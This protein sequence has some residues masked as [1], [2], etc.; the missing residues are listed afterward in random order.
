MF[1]SAT[2]FAR[3]LAASLALLATACTTEVAPDIPTTLQGRWTTDTEG[4]EGREIQL[5][6]NRLMIRLGGSMMRAHP[7]DGIESA[8]YGIQTEFRILFRNEEGLADEMILRY[9]NREGDE[10]LRIRNLETVV[11]RKASIG[12]G[13]EAAGE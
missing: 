6:G 9:E 5:A 10:T 11:W 1:A 12:Q 4:Y 2:R 3:L 8:P 13:A 7:I